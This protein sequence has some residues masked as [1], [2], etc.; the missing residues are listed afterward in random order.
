MPL[1]AWTGPSLMKVTQSRRC[2]NKLLHAKRVL[3]HI[4]YRKTKKFKYILSIRYVNPSILDSKHVNHQFIHLHEGGYVI[5][6]GHSRI[7][8][9]IQIAH[10]SKIVVIAIDYRM[11]PLY[12]F[13]TAVGDVL[14]GIKQL[15][16]DRILWRFSRACVP[17][18]VL[19]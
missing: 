15:K 17:S 6:G 1:Y 12:P 7:I 4:L 11:S 10:Y 5:S 19:N 2:M 18:L 8:E 13:P 9:A 16:S 14:A 3:S